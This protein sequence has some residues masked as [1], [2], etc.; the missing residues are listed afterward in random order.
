MYRDITFLLLS[1]GEFVHLHSVVLMF[2][3]GFFV[4]KSQRSSLNFMLKGHKKY[5]LMCNKSN[6]KTYADGI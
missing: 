1:F 2:G 3:L 5:M 6:K 4:Y